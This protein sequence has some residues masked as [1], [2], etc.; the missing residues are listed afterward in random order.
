MSWPTRYSP[1][2]NWVSRGPV[3]S[4]LGGATG[5]ATVT[6]LV[7]CTTRRAGV[8]VIATTTATITAMSTVPAPI[9]TSRI[10]R[11]PRP[12]RSLVVARV[13]ARL[14]IPASWRHLYLPLAIPKNGGGERARAHLIGGDLPAAGKMGA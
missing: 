9:T 3:A 4:T 7:G 6:V 13:S 5:A 8:P 14:V 10:H 1:S 11:P 2:V 12:S